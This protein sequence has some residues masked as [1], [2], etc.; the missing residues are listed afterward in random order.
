MTYLQQW[1]KRKSVEVF[2]RLIV[3][4]KHLII[5]LGPLL[6]IRYAYMSVF[7]IPFNCVQVSGCTCESLGSGVPCLTLEPRDTEVEYVR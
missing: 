6:W 4:I 1:F 5:F 7:P 3:V 2:S